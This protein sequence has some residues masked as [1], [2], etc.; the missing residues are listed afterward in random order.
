MVQIKPQEVYVPETQ[1]GVRYHIW[2]LVTSPPFENFIMLLIILNTLL[3]M[4][5]VYYIHNCIFMFWILNPMIFSELA[6][7]FILAIYI[8]QTLKKPYVRL[9][10][11]KAKA[12]F[13]IANSIH[14]V[15]QYISTDYLIRFKVKTNAISKIKFLSSYSFKALHWNSLTSLRI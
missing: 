7:Q 3:L 13:L 1:I 4:C 14:N 6:S 10:N 9:R 8:Y 15:S 12:E 5:K 11:R 2:R